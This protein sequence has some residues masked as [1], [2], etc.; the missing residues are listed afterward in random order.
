MIFDFLY[1][2]WNDLKYFFKKYFIL[3]QNGGSINRTKYV[4]DGSFCLHEYFVPKAF[5]FGK[6]IEIQT[7]E[8]DL[9]SKSSIYRLA[10]IIPNSKTN[11]GNVLFDNDISIQKLI[12]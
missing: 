12:L 1:D 5:N 11:N 9:C 10:P 7:L 8:I 2:F 3:F 6:F 4:Y